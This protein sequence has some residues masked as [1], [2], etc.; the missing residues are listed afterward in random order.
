MRTTQDMGCGK[1][2]VALGDLMEDVLLDLYKEGPNRVAT[3]VAKAQYMSYACITYKK[4]KGGFIL[5][6]E[7][8]MIE[9]LLNPIY[10]TTGPKGHYYDAMLLKALKCHGRYQQASRTKSRTE[11][12]PQTFY[13]T[14]DDALEFEKFIKV[15]DYKP[16]CLVFAR[17]DA[18]TRDKL[19]VQD[20]E[21]WEGY[22]VMAERE[23]RQ[24]CLQWR[25]NKRRRV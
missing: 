17:L 22:F 24:R 11:R 13:Y 19:L 5:Q 10:V 4:T 9:H 20:S 7:L 21:A 25:K 14:E 12:I 23:L 16:A 6:G 15:H 2:L 3:K 8:Q 18:V 1:G